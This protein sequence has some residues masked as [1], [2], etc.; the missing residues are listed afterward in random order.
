MSLLP[1]DAT[2]LEHVQ[3]YFLAFRGDGVALSPLDAELLLDWKARGVPYPV[4][5]RGIRRAAEAL[6]YHGAPGARLRTLRSCRVTVEREFRRWAGVPVSPPPGG[7]APVAAPST[8]ENVAV[9]RLKKARAVLR[10]ALTTAASDAAR[11]GI[12]AS[13]AVVASE[14]DDPRHVSALIARADDTLALVY[15]RQLPFLARQDLMR[16]AREAAGP[17]PPGSSRLA[18]KDALR[19]HRVALARA[20]GQ[21][22]AIT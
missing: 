12:E 16:K 3:A 1:E 19:A 9:S 4:I 14:L 13:A 7:D 10:K 20:H 17:R 15:L 5:C 11:A 6:L 18:R 22:P 8:H 2:Y 21:L